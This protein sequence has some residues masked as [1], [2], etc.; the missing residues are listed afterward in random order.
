MAD[1]KNEITLFEQRVRR[2]LRH[3]SFLQ[4]R[5]R[6]QRFRPFQ[7][8]GIEYREHSH[9]DFLAYLLDPKN[10][11]GFGDHFLR[12][13]IALVADSPA[14]T[15]DRKYPL[16][17]SAELTVDSSQVS[18]ARERNQIDILIDCYP[19]GPVI[20]IEVKIW[21]AEQENQLQTYQDRLLHEYPDR[22]RPRIMVFLTPKGNMPG[23]ATEG[24]DVPCVLLSWGHIADSLEDV[25]RMGTN[26]DT[27]PFIE[28]F[29][30]HLKE[31]FMG[32]SEDREL[33][34]SL[35]KD[36]ELVELFRE[37]NRIRPGLWDDKASESLLKKCESII[38][39]LT[40]QGVTKTKDAEI[41]QAKKSEKA[42]IR[43]IPEAW[44][45]KYGLPICFVFY[46][47][48]SWP[49]QQFP[50]FHVLL[51]RGDV[52]DDSGQ[53]S[54]WIKERWTQVSN[55]SVILAPELSRVPEWNGYSVFNS[56]YLG[57]A[58][59]RTGWVFRD[60]SFDKEWMEKV[61]EIFR[62]VLMDIHDEIENKL[63]VKR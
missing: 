24:H 57:A 10:P 54:D 28:A 17:V 19:K 37:I 1:T 62:D 52:D 7:A 31:S 26:E 25:S 3:P 45:E 16:P 42:Y 53:P 40:G 63:G 44:K 59:E 58:R 38:R 23:T 32:S 55:G 34:G 4:L 56:E 27:R 35:F 61:T 14:V 50:G 29:S 2:L 46:H 6:K 39:D 20:G 21:A 48:I 51:Y 36:P 49:A 12:E 41:V 5:R 47:D 9:S 11:H 60:E 15:R 43:I 18:V 22:E 8:L 33:V 13:F 30:R